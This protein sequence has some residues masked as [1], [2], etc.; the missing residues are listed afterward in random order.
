[1]RDGKISAGDRI[2]DAGC[3]PSLVRPLE[4]RRDQEA[5]A[6]GDWRFGSSAFVGH[7]FLVRRGSAAV[8]RPGAA[9]LLY[10]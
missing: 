4:T 8:V 10:G 6:N 1:M 2:P 7:G 3:T 9:I 5:A